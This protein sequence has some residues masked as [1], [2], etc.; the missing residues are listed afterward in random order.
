MFI[1]F[2]CSMLDTCKITVG[3]RT[4]VGP[5]VSFFA[6][7]HPT[8]KSVRNGTQGPELGAAITVGE[9]CWFGGNVVVLPGVTIGDG[10]V[11]GAGSVVTKDVPADTVV[12]GNPA[13]VVRYLNPKEGE[14]VARKEK[15]E[16][17]LRRLEELEREM[18]E[19]KG[20]LKELV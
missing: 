17:L 10:V 20:R 12:A 5:N 6:G 7:T 13:R 18:V 4:L 8:D 15:P 16:E 9:D 14:T 1:N 11:V 19:V 2:N 3:A